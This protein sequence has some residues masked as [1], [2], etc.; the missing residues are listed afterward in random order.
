MDKFKISVMCKELFLGG[1]T[2]YSA[3]PLALSM[4]YVLGI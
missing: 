4:V 2:A 3:H 1:A